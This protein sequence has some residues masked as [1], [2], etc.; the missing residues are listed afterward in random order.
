[1][2]ET[3]GLLYLPRMLELAAIYLFVFGALSVAGGILGFVKA[4]SRA[5]LIAGGASG[6]LLIAAGYLVGGGHAQVGLVLGIVL[7]VALA[8]RF[9]PGFLRTRKPMPGGMMALLSVGGIVIG[10]LALLAR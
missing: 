1:V 10:A 9:V 8:A 2:V 3:R 6:A 5:S 4:R 7:S